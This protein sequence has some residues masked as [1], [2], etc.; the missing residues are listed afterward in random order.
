MQR[1]ILVRTFHSLIALWVISIIVFALIR[2]SG[3]PADA[4]LDS[5]WMSAEQMEAMEEYWGVNDPLL[6]QYFSYLGKI[7]TGDFGDSFTHQGY[8]VRELIADRFPNTLQ[9]AGIAMLLSVVMAVPIGVLSALKKDTP[10]DFGGKIVALLGQSLP[11]FWTGIVLIWIFAVKLGWVPTSGKGGIDHMILPGITLGWFSVA[12]LMRLVRSS[13]LENLDSEYV[14]LARIK[15]IREWKVVWKHCLRNAAI[16][17]LTY[18]GVFSAA[19]LTGSIITETVFAWPGMGALILQG[20]RDRD[21]AVV[22]TVT[23]FFAFMFI[24]AN[25][26][27][28]ILYAYL[29]PRIRYR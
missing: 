11:S 12:A 15:G 7:V 23:L 27:V 9:L 26:L 20:V 17:P 29:D 5:E 13:M 14:K 3:S 28:D 4:L 2:A 21:Y 1:F 6:D 25:L 19:I 8:T 16:A 22:Q 24:G 10:A 18:F